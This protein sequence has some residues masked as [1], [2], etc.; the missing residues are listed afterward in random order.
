MT[1]AIIPAR[2]RSARFPGKPLAM[3]QGKTMIQRVYDQASKCPAFHR[4]IVATDDERILSEVQNFGGEAILT[5]P[6]HQSGT[7][8][9][10]EVAAT[11]EQCPDFVVNLQGDEP[12]VHPEQLQAVCDLLH[13][14][15]TPIATLARRIN[16]NEELT[17]PNIVKVVVDAQGYAL[18]F[19]RAPLPHQR[20]LP[21]DYWAGTGLYLKHIG[22]Y[23]FRFDVLQKIVQ[24]PP[25]E[26]ERA[27]MLE[28]LRW[29]AFGYRIRIAETPHESFSVDT[30][31]DLIRAEKFLTE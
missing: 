28:Q 29:L 13:Q 19:S 25:H 2:Y 1:V 12:F 7:E 22:V 26:L 20:D 11:L 5:A 6:T 17:N 27:E 21:L 30:A 10:A 15:D 31:E 23:G 24:L 16:R 18:Y 9:C 3:I 14:S 4:I 8:R